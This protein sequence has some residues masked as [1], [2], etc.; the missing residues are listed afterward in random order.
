[1]D[2]PNAALVMLLKENLEVSYN[3][4]IEIIITV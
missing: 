4:E 1:M 3:P 2:S